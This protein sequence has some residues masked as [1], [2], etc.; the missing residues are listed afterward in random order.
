MSDEIQKQATE[1][2]TFRIPL[3]SISQLREDS[4]RSK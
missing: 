4:K 2:I 1:G 3:G